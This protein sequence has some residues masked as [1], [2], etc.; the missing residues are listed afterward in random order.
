MAD[1][2]VSS[3]IHSGARRWEFIQFKAP[4]IGRWRSILEMKHCFWYNVA[5]DLF[6]F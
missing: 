5:L 2:G 4:P 3:I 6:L 1:K